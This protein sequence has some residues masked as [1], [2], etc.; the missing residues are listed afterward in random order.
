MGQSEVAEFRH[1]H[2]LM[3]QTLPYDRE[4]D[5]GFDFDPDFEEDSM[6][7]WGAQAKPRV[8]PRKYAGCDSAI[9]K[10]GILCQKHAQNA[11]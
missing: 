11:D 2:G 6:H 1:R 4:N 7:F 10:A 5:L 9:A 3:E 8:L